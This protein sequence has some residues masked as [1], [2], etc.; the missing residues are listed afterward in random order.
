M[1]PLVCG[2]YGI[3]INYSSKA[4]PSLKKLVK[5]L[6]SERKIKSTSLKVVL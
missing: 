5:L 3:F 2:G 4:A 6:L 1:N